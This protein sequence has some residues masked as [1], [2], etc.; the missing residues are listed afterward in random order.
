MSAEV[1]GPRNGHAPR[2]L[3][4]PSI[5]RARD[6]ASLE[7]LQAFRPLEPPSRRLDLSAA[8]PSSRAAL[9]RDIASGAYDHDGRNSGISRTSGGDPRKIEHAYRHATVTTQARRARNPGGL[10][11]V[12]NQ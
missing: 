9:R 7:V 2:I 10:S 11:G 6:V 12:D 1:R 3:P 8:E 5:Q 4:S